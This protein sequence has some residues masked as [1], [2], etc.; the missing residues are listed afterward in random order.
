MANIDLTRIRSNIQGLNILHN[1]RGVNNNLATHQLRVGTGKRINS[2]GDDPAGLTIST[3]LRSGYRVLGQLYDNIGQANNM[4]AVAEGALLNINDLLTTMNEKIVMAASDTL[5]TAERQAISQQLVQLVSE[6][7]DIAAQ[8]EFNG[9]TLLNQTATF[10]FQTAPQDQTSWT[11]R[12]YDTTSLTMANMTA[13]QT[14]DIIDTNN[15]SN[16]FDEVTVA[17]NQVSEGLTVLGSLS[18][19]LNAKGDMISVARNNTEAAYNRIYNA[20]MAHEQIEVTKYQI[21]Q[22]TSFAML[23]QANSNSQSV[24]VLFR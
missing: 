6:I 10:K 5:G 11:T 16:Y 23:A 20:D 18:N 7:N 9:V 19:R 14:T 12:A 8:T 17:V 24:L 21:L 3:K 2:A 13:L 1:L 15:Y 22:Q 4:L